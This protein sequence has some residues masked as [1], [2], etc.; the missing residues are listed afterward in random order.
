GFSPSQQERVV[1]LCISLAPFSLVDQGKRLPR[2]AARL[3]RFDF[4]GDRCCGKV[5]C[6]TERT[7]SQHAQKDE[8]P[9]ASGAN[10]FRRREVEIVFLR[11]GTRRPLWHARRLLWRSGMCNAL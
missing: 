9:D 3:P 6:H 1:R 2:E 5:K 10:F 7:N 4:S 11:N 8:L